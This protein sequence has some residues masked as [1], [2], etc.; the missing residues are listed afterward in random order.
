MTA[1]GGARAAARAQ[2][3]RPRLPSSVHSI[4]GIFR[5]SARDA[6]EPSDE[7]TPAV[8]RVDQDVLART[9]SAPRRQDGCARN[10]AR[11][12][13]SCARCAPSR[14]RHWRASS[15][16]DSRRSPSSSAAPTCMSATCGATSRRSAGS[17][18]SPRVSR[19]AGQHRRNRSGR[20]GDVAPAPGVAELSR[21][22]RGLAPDPAPSAGDCKARRG[23]PARRPGMTECGARVPQKH[24][25]A[26]LGPGSRAR[27]R[28]PFKQ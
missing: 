26:P 27:V 12:A 2:K 28:G 23:C 17:W 1:E 18:R 3:D 14:R 6:K 22:A 11:F 19:G 8:S 15:R 25:E 24:G 21:I 5:A 20:V 4:H 16:T 7:R 10:P 13:T 9:Q